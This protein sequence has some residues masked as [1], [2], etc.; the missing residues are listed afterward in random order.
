MFKLLTILALI[1]FIVPTFASHHYDIA[2]YPTLNGNTKWNVAYIEGG[3]YHD[4]DKVFKYFID[5]LMKAGWIEKEKLLEDISSKQL[6]TL[7]VEGQIES[8]F[9]SFD[10]KN[11]YSGDWNSDKNKQNA[12]KIIESANDNKIDI[13]LSAGTI[14]GLGVTNDNH[15]T[16]TI[17]FSTSN[18]LLSGILKTAS[19][20]GFDHVF[21]TISE[22]R[23]E[24]HIILFHEVTGFK[25]VGIIHE[26]TISGKSYSGIET[27]KRVA[28][29]RNFN[30]TSC[31]SLDESI[32]IQQIRETT[33]NKCAQKLISSGV[34]AI[35]V[36]EQGGANSSTV[37]N[38]AKL[39]ISEKIPT[40][41]QVGAYDVEKGI[42]MGNSSEE[43]FQNDALYVSRA[44]MAILLGVKP[45]DIPNIITSSPSVSIN[46]STANKINYTVPTV[47]R[48]AATK[49]YNRI[50]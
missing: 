38:I 50:E 5:E 23:F 15:K 10:Q 12:K 35:Y 13:I 40:F 6:W 34:D 9:L 26:N 44:F 2:I 16:P 32:D 43:E 47:L 21:A 18:A 27:V 41:S 17:A 30:V 22:G 48:G 20:T 11:F 42:L 37:K 36:T 29:K 8:D 39:A 31:L 1:F 14:A 28:E 33:F 25:N 19:T 49:I 46:M 4:Y 24:N 45:D 7:L 3:Q